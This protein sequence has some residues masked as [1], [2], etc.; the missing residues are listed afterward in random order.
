M[1]H[2]NGAT[3]RQ[4][5][6]LARQ[7]VGIQQHRLARLAQRARHLIHDTAGRADVFRLRTMCEERD[8]L[9]RKMEVELL[10]RHY[11]ATPVRQIIRVWEIAGGSRFEIDYWC[12]VCSIVMYELKECECCQGPIELRRTKVP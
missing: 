2:G 5:Q 12:D 6:Q 9:F 7:V 3:G 10:V 8:L 4:G 11:A 1:H